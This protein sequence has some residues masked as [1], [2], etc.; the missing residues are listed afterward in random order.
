MNNLQ[1]LSVA[2]A[3]MDRKESEAVENY[4]IG[5]CSMLISEQEWKGILDRALSRLRTQKA[6]AA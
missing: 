6:V 3:G 5:A 1:A 2:T 4:L